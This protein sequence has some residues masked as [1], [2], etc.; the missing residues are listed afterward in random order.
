MVS[1]SAP[2]TLDG[3]FRGTMALDIGVDLLQQL[4]G[5]GAATGT[6]I[7][8]DEHGGIVARPGD[9]AMNEQYDVPHGSDWSVGG[10]GAEW[11]ATAIV[12]GELRLVHRLPR[13]SLYRDAARASVAL[14]SALAATAVLLVLIARL[15]ITL[16][17][18]RALMQRDPLTG[19]ASRRGFLAAVGPARDAAR[20][21]GRATAI[22]VLDLD[23][24]K[25]INDTHGHNTGDRLL[26]AAARRLSTRV[27]EDDIACRWGGEELVVL[28]VYLD[29]ASLPRIAERLRER[30]ADRPYLDGSLRL[31]ASG[32]LTLW[33]W[34]ESLEAAFDRADRL[35]YEAKRAGRDRIVTDVGRQ[36]S[37]PSE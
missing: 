6:T 34:E 32:G 2:V 27:A 37:S 13:W 16:G 15:D 29:E 26:V 22:L 7:L 3:A 17:R 23:R 21:H 18:V 14:W 35:L 5:V 20:R 36:G 24:F 11:L 8:V 1:I 10:D 31:T 28:L 25:R 19:L 12:P 4:A 30:I 33:T 9:F